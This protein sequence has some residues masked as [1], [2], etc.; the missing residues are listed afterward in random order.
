MLSVLK[1]HRTAVFVSFTLLAMIAI[2]KVQAGSNEISACVSKKTGYLRISKKCSE[3]EYSLTFNKEG[4]PG[5]QGEKGEQGPQGERGANGIG[6]GGGSSIGPAGP[7]GPQG[8]AG[9]EGT[10]VTIMGSYPN[11]AALRSDDPQGAIG[12]GYIVEDTGHLFV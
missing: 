4:I 10:S 1:R 2:Q 7:T 12:S 11:E 9:N 3:K 6:G 5:P 8:P